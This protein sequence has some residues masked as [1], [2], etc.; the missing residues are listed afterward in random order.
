[1]PK[2]KEQKKEVLQE[3]KNKF[4]DAKLVVLSSYDKLPVSEIQ[5]LRIKLREKKVFYRVIKKTL[6]KLALKDNLDEG[7][8]DEL[9]GNLSLAYSPDEV[10]AAKV[11]AEFAKNNE[12]LQIHAGWLEDKFVNKAQVEELSKLL[13]KEELL[14]KFVGTLKSPISGFANVLSGN[15]RGLVNVLR[16]IAEGK[17]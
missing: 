13:S 4:A 7:L 5:A 12:D 11:L 8:I 9:R 1:M 2:N 6:L 16:A 14:S 10:S 3:I 15:T 17:S